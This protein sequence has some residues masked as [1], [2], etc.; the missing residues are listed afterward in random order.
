MQW[1]LLKIGKLF[2]ENLK[3][4]EDDMFFSLTD[5]SYLKNSW[6]PKHYLFIDLIISL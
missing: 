3:S 4:Y 6:Q 1:F 5:W 2:I